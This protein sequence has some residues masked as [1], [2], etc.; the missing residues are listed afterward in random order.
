MFLKKNERIDFGLLLKIYAT[1][2]RICIWIFKQN[3]NQNQPTSE[4]KSFSTVPSME[5][6]TGSKSGKECV[7]AVYCHPASVQF[8]SVSQ[9]CL[10][11]CNPMDCGTPG[12]PV[13]H[14][15]LKFTQ[16]HVHWVGDAIQPSHP[17]L[18]PSP[19]AQSFPASRSFP[20][21]QLFASGGQSIGVSAST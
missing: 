14:Q 12:L 2:H 19:P 6:Q 7:N 1:K 11:L 16:T 3:Q 21:S 9:S 18:S 10:T 20:V 4:Q 15:L 17:P 13:H 5:Q 8:S